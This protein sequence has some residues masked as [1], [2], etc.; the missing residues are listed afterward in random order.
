MLDWD[1]APHEKEYSSCMRFPPYF[2]SAY[3]LVLLESIDHISRFST[4]TVAFDVK[5]RPPSLFPAN[6]K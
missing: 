4:V 6:Q 2:T 3:A 5:R 1:A